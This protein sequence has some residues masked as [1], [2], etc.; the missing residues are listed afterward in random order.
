M[1]KEE[2]REKEFREKEKFREWGVLCPQPRGEV[3]V[4]DCPPGFQGSA[5]PKNGSGNVGCSYFHGNFHIVLEKGL[6]RTL[7]AH[8]AGI[9]GAESHTVE[10]PFQQ[11]GM[12][13]MGYLW[14]PKKGE[15]PGKPGQLGTV[16]EDQTMLSLGGSW[17]VCIPKNNNNKK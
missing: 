2:F 14:T 5:F 1:G 12:W 15:F 11:D 3:E 17:T 6:D 10:L 8:P 4:G 7:R 13:T 9:H 16:L